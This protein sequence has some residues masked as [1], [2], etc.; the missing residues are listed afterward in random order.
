MGS[1]V[2]VAAE[3]DDA[4]IQQQLKIA[5][6]KIVVVGAAEE[7][8]NGIYSIIMENDEMILNGYGINNISWSDTNRFNTSELLVNK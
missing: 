6:R 8:A 7:D 4:Y 2:S 3:I 5:K 1:G